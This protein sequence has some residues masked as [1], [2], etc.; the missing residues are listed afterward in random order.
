MGSDNI[1]PLYT[2]SMKLSIYKETPISG[3]QLVILSMEAD[4]SA[5]AKKMERTHHGHAPMNYG[6]QQ[7][8]VLLTE[9]YR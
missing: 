3:S 1:P 2:N 7:T 4:G 9:R 6:Y 8:K 5:H